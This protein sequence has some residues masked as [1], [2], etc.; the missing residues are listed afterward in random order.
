MRALHVQDWFK[1]TTP[2]CVPRPARFVNN[3]ANF[4]SPCCQK[5]TYG[6]GGPSTDRGSV[7]EAC[8]CLFGSLN[9]A[10]HNGGCGAVT[11]YT[12]TR[13]NLGC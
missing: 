9:G 5:L 7:L 13:A 2:D 4:K 12:P 8:Q 1:C 11:A 3:G 10:T 6:G